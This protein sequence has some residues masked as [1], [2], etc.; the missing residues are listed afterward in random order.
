ME[1]ITTKVL[2]IIEKKKIIPLQNIEEKLDYRYLDEGHVD[3]FSLLNL[4]LELESEFD[5]KLS[6]EDTESDNFRTPRGIV[7]IING[8]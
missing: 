7:L 5:I 4:I 3:S 2:A 1:D 8:K 6:A